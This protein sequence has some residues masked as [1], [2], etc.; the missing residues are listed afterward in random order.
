MSKSFIR[1]FIARLLISLI[2]ALTLTLPTIA[3][4]SADD[5]DQSCSYAE[6][7]GEDQGALARFDDELRQ[8]LTTGH[9]LQLLPLIDFP[10][11]LN[12]ANRGTIQ[13]ADAQALM[14][15]YPMIFPAELKAKILNYKRAEIGCLPQ[16]VMYGPGEL[17]LR[18]IALENN[19]LTYRLMAI[20]EVNDE[21]K[22]DSE[23]D[24]VKMICETSYHRIV[25]DEQQNTPRY[26]AWNKP[27]SL[28]LAPDLEIKQGLSDYE[29]TGPCT[30]SIWNFT[31]GSTSLQMSEISPCSAEDSTRARGNLEIFI[32]GK[33]AQTLICY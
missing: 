16:G 4:D 5:F 14:S 17:W 25:I 13:I 33:S 28:T 21:S 30:S 15:F 10:L 1:S 19:Q 9:H 6:Y 2:P 22:L 27:R 11:R 3:L 18:P 31:S 23:A 24:E 8:A 20:N 7:G 29:G 32:Q 12:F 26:R